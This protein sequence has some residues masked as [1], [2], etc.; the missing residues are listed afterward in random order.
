M[1]F[2]IP[3]LA[4]PF[5]YQFGKQI[6]VQSSQVSG[7]SA[8]LDFTLLVSLIDPDLRSIANGGKV[9]NS[10]GY[11]ITFTQEDCS[12]SLSHQIEK[13]DPLTGEYIAWVKIPSLSPS[14]NTI[15]GMYYGNNTVV[16]N[17]STSLAWGANAAAVY[18]LSNNDF[19][20]A[21]SNG[22]NATNFSTVNIPGQIG[23]AR[24]FNGSSHY[25]N[26]PESGTTSL[27]LIELTMS[28]WIFPTNY[29]V[30]S[31]RG[32]I[33][34]KESTYEMGLQDNTGA[35]QAAS[36][37]GC[38][39]WAGTRII[40][41]STWSKVTIVFAGG[42]QKHYVNGVFIQ[43]LSNCSNPLTFNDQNLRIGARGGNGGPSSYYVGNI[44]E[45]KIT[46]REETADW[47]ATE[48]NNQNTPSTF[49]TVSAEVRANS[50]CILLPIK[51]QNFDCAE[52]A[53]Q[54]IQIDWETISEINSDYFIVER[55]SNGLNWEELKKVDA[56][57]NSST[58]QAYKAFD[59]QA[60]SPI[61]YYRLKQVDSDGQFTYSEIRAVRFKTEQNKSLLVYPNPATNQI[62]LKAEEQEELSQIRLFNSLGKEVTTFIKLVEKN[63]TKAIL[64]IS[65]LS[66][67]IYYIQ[68]KTSRKSIQK[69]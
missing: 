9:A 3:V 56:V 30:V 14:I 65:N 54:T 41:L 50:I 19:R 67:G 68:T 57:G 45:V 59:Y 10:N 46:N 35:F 5:N 44:D 8:L 36:N 22:M 43:S 69:K 58:L 53:D 39:R 24:S 40:P 23:D 12:T 4:Q 32:I 66:A 34:N 25:L 33:L 28:A 51:M 18:H 63:K 31:D 21:T 38:W 48:Y 27:D 55:S 42:I 47:I 60:Y 7:A 17:P 2:S 16:S 11:D 61:S 1:Y 26:V 20:D 62:T 52:I 49:Y 64:D 29:N 15:I 6:E 37:P 13:Y